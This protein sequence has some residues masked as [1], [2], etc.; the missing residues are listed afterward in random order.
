MKLKK[1]KFQLTN[2]STLTTKVNLQKYLV[3]VLR[4]YF[5]VGTLRYEDRELLLIIMSQVKSLKNYMTH[6][7]VFKAVN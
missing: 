7:L 4:G 2:Y 6:I 1:E 3:Q 5:S